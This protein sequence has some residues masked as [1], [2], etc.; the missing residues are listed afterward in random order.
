[1]KASETKLQ[2]VIEGTNQY[3]VPLFQ[4]KYSWDSK[5]WSTLW[6]DL[7]ELYEEEKPRSHFIGSIVTMPT[8]SVPEGVAKFLLIDGQQ[9]FTTILILLSVLRDKAR[10]SPSNTLAD[11]IEQTL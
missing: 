10:T 3:V 4:R 5:E 2:R 11:E 7:V 1:M 9:R 6:D 8:Q